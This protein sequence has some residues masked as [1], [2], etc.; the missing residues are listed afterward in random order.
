[1]ARHQ[2]H[3]V[4]RHAVPQAETSVRGPRADIVA[5][6]VEGE[7]VNV[8][9]VTVE[10]PERLA[11]VRGPEAGSSVVAARGKV[12]AVGGEGAVPDREHVALVDHEAGPGQQRPQPHRPVLGAGQQ[13]RP[14]WVERETKHGS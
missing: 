4:P 1:M 9:E 10:D 6:W 2:S 7:T 14:V 8:G 12:V 13:Q 11:L 3:A 5:V